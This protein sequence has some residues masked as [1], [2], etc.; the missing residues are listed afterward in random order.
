MVSCKEICGV[1][2]GSEWDSRRSGAETG[3]VFVLFQSRDVVIHRNCSPSV[4]GFFLG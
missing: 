4:E 3:E 1:A 2:E